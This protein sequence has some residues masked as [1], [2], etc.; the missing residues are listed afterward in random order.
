MQGDHYVGF[1]QTW[2]KTILFLLGRQWLKWLDGK[3]RYTTDTDV[4]AWRQQPVTNVVYAVYRTLATKL[5]K[6]K[7]TLEVGA[8][9]RRLERPARESARLG[10]S[11]LVHLWRLLKVPAKMRRAIGWFLCTGQVYLRVH[12]DADAG[13]RVP[14]TQLVEVPNPGLRSGDRR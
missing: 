11:I 3:R 7:P 6:L 9:V 1:Y 14:L 13:R 12:W 8:A 10:Q 2:V 4:P 5:T